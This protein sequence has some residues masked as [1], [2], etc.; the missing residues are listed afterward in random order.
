[1]A[2]VHDPLAPAAFVSS[3]IIDVGG[4]SLASNEFVRFNGL[5]MSS[6]QPLAVARSLPTPPFASNPFDVAWMTAPAERQK[7]EWRAQH[8]KLAD[9]LDRSDDVLATLREL[10]AEMTDARQLA[11]LARWSV[12][13]ADDKGS[14]VWEMLNDRQELVRVAGVERLLELPQRVKRD[15]LTSEQIRAAVGDAAADSLIQWMIAAQGSKPLSAAHAR[16]MV[17]YLQHQHLAMRQVAVSLLEHYSTAAFQQA[18]RKP[19]HY[20]AAAPANKRAAAQLEW[21]RIIAQLYLPNRASKSP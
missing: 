14:A 21:R 11:L 1:M 8:G 2:I 12:T 20:D 7:K 18:R 15:L 9:R 5:T 19:P 3:G 17:G 10:R 4:A 13:L 16:E 6:P